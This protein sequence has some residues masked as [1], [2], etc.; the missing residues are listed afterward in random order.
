MTDG[1]VS[2]KGLKRIAWFDCA[3]GGQVRVEGRYAY[4]GHM[5]PPHGTSI[6]DIADPRHP[7][8][9][10]H[11]PLEGDH[12][13]T[14]KV[15]VAGDLMITNVE[16]NDRHQKRRAKRL[17]EIEARFRA[18][19]GRD[20]TEAELAKAIK[21]PESLMPRMRQSLVEPPYA[22]G[23]FRVWDI[24]DRTKPRLLTHQRTGGIGVHRFDMDARYA[25]IS[26]EMEG[27]V[28]NILVIYD[29]KDPARPEEVSRWWMPGQHLAGGEVPSWEG[30]Q[31][32]LHH[33][34]RH[35]DQL[36]AAVWYAGCRIIDVSD[37]ARPRTIGE[38]RYHPPFPEPTHTFLRVPFKV[39]GRTLAVAVDEEH[40]HVPGQLHGGLWVFDVEDPAN[41]TPVSMFH[42]SE[43]ASPYI[44][45]G[46]RFGAHQFQER[47][48][49][50]RLFTAWFG[51]GLRVVDI[52]KPDLPTET[53]HWLAEPP[54][55][56]SS[57]QANDVDLDDRGLVYV[58]DR[59]R[60]LEVLEVTG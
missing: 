56:E 27:Y 23:G 21:V 51:G 37:I 60:G 34:L 47:M 13:H 16:Q 38:Y 9:L 54:P 4:I 53:G 29:L 57:P 42:A 28:G 26:T 39:A 58:L 50:T 55:G 35:E 49:D 24:S 48:Q 22:D 45:T 15:R 12:S 10:A 33:T 11:I 32:R 17:P 1:A 5:K 41:I 3:G 31:H 36:Y 43:L 14:H 30:Q 46:G 2:A 7:R 20:A 6:L 19:H 18:E 8:L 25:Y 44:R 52:A 40:E 59:N